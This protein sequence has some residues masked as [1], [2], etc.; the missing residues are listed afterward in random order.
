MGSFPVVENNA[1]NVLKEFCYY[2]GIPKFI[3]TDNGS[4]YNNNLF[5]KFCDK[6]NIQHINRRPPHPQTNGVVKVLHKEIRRYVLM[7]FSEY[8]NDFDLKD[9]IFKAINIHNHKI[10]SSTGFRPCDIINNT[11]EDI[12]KKVLESI[13]KSLKLNNNNYDDIKED[14]KEIINQLAQHSGKK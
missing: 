1:N 6:H 9:V 2:V 8:N 4:E 14:D 3:Q 12:Q 10:H 13:K 5:S 11:N 7:K